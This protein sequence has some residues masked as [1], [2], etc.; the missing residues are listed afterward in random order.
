MQRKTQCI[1][2]SARRRGFVLVTMALAAAGVFGIVGL[3]LDIGRMF[4]AKNETQIY[5]DSAAV[6]GALALDGTG[7]GINMAESAIAATSN[8][9]DFGTQ[10]IANPLVTFATSATGPWVSRPNPA[11]GYAYVQVAVTAPVSLYFL[12]VLI[13]QWTSNVTSAAVAGQVP[14]GSLSRG[15]SPYTAVSTDTSGPAFGLVV[16]RSYTIHWPT[17]N[18]NRHGCGVGSPDSCFNTPP[19][20]G[21]P[22]GSLSAVV[23]NWGSQYH[24]YWGSNSN[25]DI[26]AAVMNNIQLAPV[27]VGSNLDPLLTPG[28]KQSEAGYLDRRAS[29]DGDTSDN[30]PGDYLANTRHNGRRLLPVPIVS[31]VDPDRTIVIGF[32]QFLLLA[33]GSPSDYYNRSGNGNSPYCAVYVGPFNIG[34]PGPGAGGSTGAS[35]VRLVR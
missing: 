24:G 15:L 25:K 13:G 12:P 14:T 3:S 1:R 17:Y 23:A 4:I 16:G 22:N 32:G 27:T 9:W 19:C 30:T 10:S 31:P 28:N 18:G 21:D 8:K 20:S 2:R 26:A 6:A 35:S 5:C 29:Q 11:T 33:N 34:S 7:A